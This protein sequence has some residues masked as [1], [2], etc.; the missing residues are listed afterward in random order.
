MKLN[1]EMKK[2]KRKNKKNNKKNGVTKKGN[3]KITF[4]SD[5]TN[6]IEIDDLNVQELLYAYD[7]LVEYVIGKTGEHPGVINAVIVKMKR[8]EREEKKGD[9][10]EESSS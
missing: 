10:T 4:F 9:E 8:E 7:S 6:T 1:K 3:L 2:K 5:D